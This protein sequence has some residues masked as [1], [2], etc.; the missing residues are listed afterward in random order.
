VRSATGRADGRASG[1]AGVAALALMVAIAG[2]AIAVVVLGGRQATP[3]G[4]QR[5]A[6]PDLVA[7]QRPTVLTIWPE[8]PTTLWQHDA[9]TPTPE[10]IQQRVNAGE[11]DLQWRADP[12]QVVSRFAESIFGWDDIELHEQRF[13]DSPSSPSSRR[14]YTI[15]PTC[16]AA[17]DCA[18]GL[19]VHTVV[20][21]RPVPDHEGGIWSVIAVMSPRLRI[22]ADWSNTDR[23]LSGRDALPMR[24]DPRGSDRLSAG[25]VAGNGC[26]SSVEVESEGY[27]GSVRAGPYELPIPNAAPAREVD[28][29]CG[30]IG[31]GYAFAYSTPHI[32]VPVGDPLL[33]PGDV[34]DVTIVPISLRM[35]ERDRSSPSDS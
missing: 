31:V 2:T 5:S 14:W 27:G 20:L 22:D 19:Q 1:R 10:D 25:L 18:P 15:Q 11:S 7:W 26:A 3:G 30:A 34:S 12:R 24:L 17:A 8:N 4:V 21:Q 32:S 9:S 33:E 29:T 28:P 16:R 35:V 13:V 6:S 23:A